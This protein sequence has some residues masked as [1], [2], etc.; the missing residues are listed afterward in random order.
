MTNRMSY[1]GRRWLFVWMLV[2][3][4]L[5]AGVAAAFRALGGLVA[6]GAA[7]PER[8]DVIVALGGDDG[9]RIRKAA[10]LFAAGYAPTVL[11]TGLE[12]AP[13]AE[14]RGYLEWRAQ[15]LAR[16]GIPP[17]R[18]VF[19]ATAK[20]SF[21]EAAATLALMRSRGWQT[22]LVVSDPPHMRRLDWVWG[23]V[24][25]GSSKTYRLVAS[26]PAWW[27]AA[28]WWRNEKS[29]QFVITELIKMAY[30]VARY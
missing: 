11:I 13:E 9:H 6:A 12:G 28:H 17:E 29:G 10:S 1:R 30:Y 23:R 4:L 24:F 25:A 20:N 18:V 22:A 16:R 15:V 3:V 27:D 8:A 14:R 5:L 19:E 26:E 2:A 7:A 21:E